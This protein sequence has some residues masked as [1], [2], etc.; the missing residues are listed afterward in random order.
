MPNLKDEMSARGWM[1][2]GRKNEHTPPFTHLFLDG[3]R[4]AVPD[5]MH[6]AFLNLYVNAILRGERVYVVETK[7]THF[8]LFFDIDAHYETRVPPEAAR[9]ELLTLAERLNTY[10]SHFWDVPDV[11]KLIVCSAP[12]KYAEDGSTYKTGLH[13]H[14]PT[15]VTNSPIA[16]AFRSYVLDHIEEEPLALSTTNRLEDI[17]DACVF[18]ANGLRLIYSGKVDHYRAY[19]PCAV[20]T[21]HGIQHLDVVSAE[22][23]RELV[24]QTSIRAFDLPLTACRNGADKL[25]D[26][27]TYAHAKHRLGIQR[28]LSDYEHLLPKLHALLPTV[29]ATQRFTGVFKTDHA[30]MFKSSSRFCFNVER[31]HRTS[32]IYFIV[33]RRGMAQRCYCRKDERG[34]VDYCSEWIAVPE[35]ILDEL[36]PKA[37]ELDEATIVHVMPSKKT[38][39][40]DLHAL[41]S[42]CKPCA[43]KKPTTKKSKKRRVK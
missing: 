4:A 27:A 39:V 42:R 14:W 36:L 8:R 2:G 13:L 17:L 7:T 10:A 29:Y 35:D 34:C 6:G 5:T 12:E 3:G 43:A 21:A 20:I 30:V 41:L 15:I 28:R 23:K 19:E 18:K 24:H 32:T 33:T 26:E 37:E 9:H 40:N 22:L 25:A 11:Q 31:E 38:S 16:M 1:L